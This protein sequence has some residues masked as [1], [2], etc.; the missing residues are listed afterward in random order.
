MDRPQ[1]WEREH[2][3]AYGT[4]L[5]RLERTIETEQD[6]LRIRLVLALERGKVVLDDL[7]ARRTASAIADA[8]AR[9][10]CAGSLLPIFIIHLQ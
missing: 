3:V 2:V 5:R 8:A 10:I 4:D 1:R 9:F 6:F 7:L